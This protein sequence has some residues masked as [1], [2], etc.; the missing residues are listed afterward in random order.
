MSEKL[1]HRGEERTFSF[2]LKEGSSAVIKVRS[3]PLESFISRTDTDGI[4]LMVGGNHL[5]TDE[6]APVEHLDPLFLLAVNHEEVKIKRHLR[7]MI[8][9]YYSESNHMVHFASERKALWEIGIQNAKSLQPGERLRIR[10]LGKPFVVDADDARR[11]V[12]IRKTT[13]EEVIR[14]LAF[15]LGNSFKRIEGRRAGVLFSGG[16]DSSLVALLA[17]EVCQEVQLYSAS[18]KPFHDRMAAANAADALGMHLN[19]IEIKSDVVWDVLPHL[20]HAIESAHLMDV[21]IALPFYLASSQAASDGVPL[22]LSGQGPDELFAGYARH[23]RI[24]EDEGEHALDTHLWNE[25]MRTHE[26]NIERDDR[27]IAFHGIESGFPYL[28]A[29]FIELALTIPS[30]W[31]VR[32]GSQPERKII[33]RELARQMG[34][35]QSISDS[36]KKATQYSSG[37]SRILMKSLVENV[38]SMRDIPRKEHRIRAQEYLYSLASE[39]GMPVGKIRDEPGNI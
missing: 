38:N 6:T 3:R 23:V 9:F 20:I 17:Q 15:A 25:V 16:V 22:M 21:E 8:P 5:S 24:F 35:P 10:G 31:K 19:Q 36:P 39:L 26:T 30:E 29:D 2:T 13:R 14:R 27:A 7:C 18:S 28:S 37:S 11:P 4:L 1:S 32:P 34:L 12:T 33:F